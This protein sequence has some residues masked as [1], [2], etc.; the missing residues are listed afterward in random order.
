MRL[1][2]SARDASTAQNG[3]FRA[4]P[5]EQASADPVACWD[6][7]LTECSR[8]EEVGVVF[9]LGVAAILNGRVASHL[10]SRPMTLSPP[11]APARPSPHMAAA[12]PRC[13]PFAFPY[14]VQP[15]EHPNLGA[16]DEIRTRD[17]HLGKVAL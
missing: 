14:G 7:M 17:L 15:P 11:P 10:R 1:R 16:V 8:S 6:Q 4:V 9:T 2:A 12:C 5:Y 13:I 3:D